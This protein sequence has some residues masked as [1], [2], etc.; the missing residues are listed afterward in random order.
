MI[1]PTY[2]F[3]CDIWDHMGAQLGTQEIQPWYRLFGSFMKVP[4]MFDILRPIFGKLVLED[5]VLQNMQS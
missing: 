3:Q 1:S 4:N 5:C 2:G